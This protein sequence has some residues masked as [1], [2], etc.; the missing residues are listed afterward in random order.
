MH[1]LAIFFFNSST[2]ATAMAT[3]SLI[4]SMKTLTTTSIPI[5]TCTMLSKSQDWMI[6]TITIRNLFWNVSVRD[7]RHNSDH[8]IVLGCLRRAPLRKHSRYLGGIKR[9]PL[10]PPTVL[11]R[12][13]RIFA[14]LRRAVPNPQAPDARKNA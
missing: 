2:C 7:P 3:W 10:R 14:A 9:L 6:M 8:Y 13:D 11:K 12:E 1:T 4:L 5:F